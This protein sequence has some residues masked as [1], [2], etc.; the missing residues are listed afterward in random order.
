MSEGKTFTKLDLKNPP[1]D[2]EVVV[3][4]GQV[5]KQEHEV[6]AKWDARRGC[7]QSPGIAPAD[8][9]KIRGTMYRKATKAEIEAGVTAAVIAERIE[10]EE[11]DE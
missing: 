4:V 9:R 10:E 3:L 2:G 1:K 11:S 7:F 6:L 8:R 5:K